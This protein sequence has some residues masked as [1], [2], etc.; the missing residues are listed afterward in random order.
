VYTGQ[1]PDKMTQPKTDPGNNIK[2]NKPFE[3]TTVPKMKPATDNGCKDKSK[4]I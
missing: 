4:K 1:V 3:S 2:E